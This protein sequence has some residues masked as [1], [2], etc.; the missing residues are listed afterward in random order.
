[1]NT[2]AALSV[3]DRYGEGEQNLLKAEKISQERSKIASVS[4]DNL[5]DW[6]TNIYM[7]LARLVNTSFVAF[8]PNWQKT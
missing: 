2:I 4:D 8:K 1:M 6:D 5:D 3:Y 7:A